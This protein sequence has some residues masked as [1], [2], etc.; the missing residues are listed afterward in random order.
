MVSPTTQVGVLVL[1]GIAGLALIRSGSR[2]GLPP[3]SSDLDRL[4]RTP[5]A[6][7]PAGRAV[8]ARLVGTLSASRPGI[9]VLGAAASDLRVLGRTPEAE[10]LRRLATFAVGGLAGPLLAAAAAAGGMAISPTAVLFT[11]CAGAGVA[12]LHALTGTSRA[13]ARRRRA[14]RWQLAMILLAVGM[15]LAMSQGVGTAL[16]AATRSRRPGLVEE[17]ARV[18]DRSRLHRQT[19]WG[20]L[21]VLGSDLGISDLV[22]VAENLAL[23]GDDGARVRQTVM[24]KADALLVRILTE[25]E[26]E[27]NEATEAMNLPT[28]VL[29]LAFM[30]FVAVPAMSWAFGGLPG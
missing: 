5:S 21:G 19:P 2:P 4:R 15:A 3:L 8:P 26:A 13:A 28:V 24:A 14:Y 23:A 30:A 10:A 9:L 1:T 29:L 16:V 6:S 20:R 25:E 12:I 22:E 11:S 18:L 27:A 7:V 17:I